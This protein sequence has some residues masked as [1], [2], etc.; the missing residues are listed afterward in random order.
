VPW[1]RKWWY[2]YDHLEYFTVVWYNLWSFG[3]FLASSDREKSGNLDEQNQGDRMVYAKN[4]Q[5]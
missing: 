4:A 1:K 5:K 3:L 2:V